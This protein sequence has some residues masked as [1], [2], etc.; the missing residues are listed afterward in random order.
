MGNQIWDFLN[1]DQNPS[2]HLFGCWSR[3]S[4]NICFVM[5]FHK[6]YP[7][8]A[9]DTDWKEAAVGGAQKIYFG[10]PAVLPEYS[11]AFTDRHGDNRAGYSVGQ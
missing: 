11:L 7:N 9:K 4:H 1:L 3:M 5:P 6:G 2:D 8:A 10:F